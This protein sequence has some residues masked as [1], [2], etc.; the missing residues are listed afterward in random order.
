[1]QKTPCQLMAEYSIKN[2]VQ[3]YHGIIE[4]KGAN[5]PIILDRYK[6][7]KGFFIKK[8]IINDKMNL[9]DWGVTWDGIKK[10]GEK[11]IGKPIVLTPDKDHPPVS[12]QEDYRV[13]EY[14]D[15]GTDEINHVL[16]GVGQIFDERAQKMIKNK[17]IEFG[18]PT[19]LV[20]S[21]ATREQKSKG[22]EFQKDILHRFNPAHDALVGDPAYGKHADH[23]KAVCE[24]DG[25]ACGLK[26]LTVSASR[27][28]RELRAANEE[29]TPE[30]VGYVEGPT[31]K[32]CITCNKFEAPNICLLPLSIPV[33][34][35]KGCCNEWQDKFNKTQTEFKNV[36]KE[37]EVIDGDNTDQLTI[38]PFVRKFINERFSKAKQDEIVGKI[39]SSKS[40]DSDSCVSRR[41]KII[42]ND[43]PEM[44]HDQAI[45]IAYSY[46]GDNEKHAAA[47]W[48]LETAVVTEILKL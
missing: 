29:Y 20:Y 8:M 7:R 23:I 40:G 21:E 27:H 10:D 31:P 43:H 19:V 18:S 1:M 38:V 14:I 24:G 13:G 36:K 34:G 26:L 30:Q 3:H 47:G 42:M 22:T 6:G 16:W 37:G 48:D 41:I 44:A 5:A 25:E 28:Y 45:A 4:L 46:C 12:K 9:N 2:K 33:D 11:F 39:M 35:K 32:Q 17:E 15:V